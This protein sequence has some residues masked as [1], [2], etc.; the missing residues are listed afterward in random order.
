[1]KISDETL[2]YVQWKANAYTDWKIVTNDKE[3]RRTLKSIITRNI[4]E[5]LEFT[6]AKKNIARVCRHAVTLNKSE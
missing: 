3:V 2:G 1:M 4:L 5:Q 6:L